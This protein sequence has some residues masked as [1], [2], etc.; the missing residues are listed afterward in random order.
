MKRSDAFP[1]RFLSKENVT[2]A[3]T[4]TIDTVTIEKLS[5]D[6]RPKPVISFLEEDSKPMII[7]NSNW[8]T[9]ESI[10][11]EESNDW[12]GKRIELFNDPTVMYS[13]KR[14]G[15]IR[16]REARNA[17]NAQPAPEPKLFAT[18]GDAV[19][20]CNGN[21]FNDVTAQTMVDAIKARG[22]SGWSPTRDSA[23]VVEEFLPNLLSFEIPF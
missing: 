6:E 19:A 17:H 1:S 13:G 8:M 5:D 20:Y 12:H 18:L 22:F 21:G 16:V 10:H 7:N 14:I 23:W 2:P 9:I 11:G 3:I 15:G 4:F